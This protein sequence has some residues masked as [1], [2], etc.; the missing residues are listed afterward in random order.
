M[1]SGFAQVH[2]LYGDLTQKEHYVKNN[3]DMGMKINFEN[4]L[5]GP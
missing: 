1:G 4:K 2:W 5:E 3:L